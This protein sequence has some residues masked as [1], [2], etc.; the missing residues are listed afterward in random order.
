MIV[1]IEGIDGAGKH[2]LSTRLVGALRDRTPA[3]EVLSFPR[4][5]HCHADLAA[6]ALRGTM[7]DL[8]ESVYGM[9]ML[10]ALDRAEVRDTLAAYRGGLDRGLLLCDRYVA[11]NAAYS[12]ARLAADPEEAARVTDWVGELEFGRFGLPHADVHVLVDTPPAAASQRAARR[13]KLEPTRARDRYERDATLQE[14]TYAAYHRLAERQ[15]CGCWLVGSD[16]ERIGA[17]VLGKGE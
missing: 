10:F 13:E 3:V 9:A 1:A 17:A 6:A 8:A 7:G 12:A 16:A 14:R 2:T 5:G 11:S 4:Y 15:W